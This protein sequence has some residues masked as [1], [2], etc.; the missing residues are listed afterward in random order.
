LFGA[1][2]QT[3]G[4]KPQTDK[5]GQTELDSTDHA[6]LDFSN[7][8]LSTYTRA[9]VAKHKTA[10]DGGIWVTYKNGVF[11]IQ[12]FVDNHPGEWSQGYLSPKYEDCAN[13]LYLNSQVATK[14][15]WLQA[16]QSIL[17]GVFTSSI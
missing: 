16:G 6:N 3:E 10:Q 14:S 9:E 11:D 2:S 1:E 13:I 12:N 5:F 8:S 17:S 15:C 7:A 4:T